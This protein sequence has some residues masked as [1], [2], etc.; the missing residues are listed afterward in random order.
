MAVS[1]GQTLAEFGQH[2]GHAAVRE[3]PNAQLN[4]YLLLEI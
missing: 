2:T 4:F 1:P 3:K